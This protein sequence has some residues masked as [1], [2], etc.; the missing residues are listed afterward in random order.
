MAKTA[1]NEDPTATIGQV[2]KETGLP[3]S[4]VRYYE[5]EF[6]T[7][8]QLLKTPGGHRRFRPGDV[9]KLKRIH[10]LV[11][12]QGMS[13]KDAKAKLVSD[14]DPV[15]MR[16]DLD[17]LL[18]VFESLVN[19]NVKLRMALEDLAARLVTLEEQG[20]KKKFRLF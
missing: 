12:G 17:L 14:R 20:K 5:K 8:L 3:V 18:E 19:E 15:L 4:T 10:A 11:H 9:E 16:R 13:L 6:G 2:S 1:E 7:Y